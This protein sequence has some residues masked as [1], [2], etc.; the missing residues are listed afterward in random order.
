MRGTVSLVLLMVVSARAETPDA[1][2]MKAIAP[3]QPAVCFSPDDLVDAEALRHYIRESE[4]PLASALRGLANARGVPLQSDPQA[5]KAR[6]Y[7]ARTRLVRLLNE[8]LC[9]AL[10]NDG[11]EAPR[12][13]A[14]ALDERLREAWR[15]TAGHLPGVRLQPPEPEVRGR[16]DLPG[17]ERIVIVWGAATIH[18]DLD[19]GR[20]A[21]IGYSYLGTGGRVLPQTVLLERART[22][23]EVRDIDLAGWQQAE[24]T[25]LDRAEERHRHSFVWRRFSDQG[26]ELP[27]AMNVVVQDNGLISGFVCVDRP[28]E[29][30]LV[31]K[32]DAASA[33][34][35]AQEYLETDA[36][37]TGQGRLRVWA[38]PGGVQ[39]LL[40]EIPFPGGITAQVN[41]H[42]GRVEQ[43]SSPES[44][45]EPLQPSP[46]A[47]ASRTARPLAWW[48][49]ALALLAAALLIRRRRVG[50]A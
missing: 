7:E 26:V 13:R 37:P 50:P 19:T 9:L 27:S 40:W 24:V 35:R 11:G 8:S 14:E 20:V 43:V 22:W 33:A 32:I 4:E 12:P 48:A 1:A 16:D 17:R 21:R 28:I 29:V 44:E 23:L 42:S 31:P 39:C 2:V 34:L 15:Q 38:N 36:A 10:G 3:F 45:A 6:D 46:R 47:A 25:V 49:P 18:V 41:A 30:E 5:G